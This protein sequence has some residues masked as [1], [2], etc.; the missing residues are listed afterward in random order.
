MTPCRLD[1]VSAATARLHHCCISP[2]ICEHARAHTHTH[3]Q[4]CLKTPLLPAAVIASFV[5][6]LARLSLASPAPACLVCLTLIHNLLRRHPTCLCLLHR[7][8]ATP[9]APADPAAPAADPYDPQVRVRPRYG[10]CVS[11]RLG[12]CVTERG[13]MASM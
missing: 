3:I 9:A 11:E 5:K 13:Q 2:C 10:A 12:A 4:V 6:R 8:V 7:I 1:G